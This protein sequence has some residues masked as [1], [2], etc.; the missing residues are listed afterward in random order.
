MN[1]AGV[2]VAG[3]LEFIPIE[4]LRRQLEVNLDRPGGRDPGRSSPPCAA[5]RGRIVNVSSIGGRMALPL[6]G[7]Y[8]ASK[9]GLEAVSDSLR[10]EVAQFGVE[11]S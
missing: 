9:F 2:A 11:V 8:A 10:R 3:P 6:A 7:P 4:E 1:N 5:A